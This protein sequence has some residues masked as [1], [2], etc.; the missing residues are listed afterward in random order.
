MSD[1]VALCDTLAMYPWFHCVWLKAA[2]SPHYPVG[3]CGSGKNFTFYRLLVLHDGIIVRRLTVMSS[4]SL[5]CDDFGQVIHAH[6][7]Y[8]RSRI[9]WFWPEGFDAMQ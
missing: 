1:C 3:P 2:E 6:Y 9:I 4:A 8:S 7:L 5:C